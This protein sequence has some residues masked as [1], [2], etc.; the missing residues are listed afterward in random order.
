MSEELYAKKRKQQE[1]DPDLE[2]KHTI[3]ICKDTLLANETA[4][5][6]EKV[7]WL[8]INKATPD[9]YVLLGSYLPYIRF[10]GSPQLWRLIDREIRKALELGIVSQRNIKKL[11]ESKDTKYN[12]NTYH[13]RDE[14]M[15][16]AKKMSEPY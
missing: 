15:E 5:I 12:V 13:I 9:D 16:L 2:V 4:K 3:F 10:G 14:T 6:L 7:F 11:I 1:E 8:N